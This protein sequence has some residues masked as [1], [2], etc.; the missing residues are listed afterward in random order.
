MSSRIHRLR[1]HVSVPLDATRT[2]A[3][4]RRRQADFVYR[5]ESMDQGLT[6]T[7]PAPTD[8]PNNNS[9][10]AAISLDDGRIAIICNPVN[11]AASPDR[12]TSL[13]DELGEQDDRPEADPTGGCA[14]VWACHERQSPSAFRAM[15]D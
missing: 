7:I 11:A 14:P 12:R 13:Y 4:F 10:I 1:A 3:F 6:W 9:S 15:A 8:L 2:A 5:T